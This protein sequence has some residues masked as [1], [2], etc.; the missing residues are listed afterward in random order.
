M[1]LQPLLVENTQVN[2]LTPPCT[3]VWVFKNK[4]THTPSF[5]TT[6]FSRIEEARATG[7]VLFVG[8]E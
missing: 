8:R 2:C 6:L 1:N 7:S 4:A 3:I 5:F